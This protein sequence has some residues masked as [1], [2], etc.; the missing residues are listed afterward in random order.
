[1]LGNMNIVI[2]AN[3]FPSTTKGTLQRCVAS[4]NSIRRCSD[5]TGD[6]GKISVFDRIAL[7]DLKLVR[8]AGS[9]VAVG[10]GGS[11]PPELAWQPVA[12]AVVQSAASRVGADRCFLLR[13][14]GIRD[15]Q[16]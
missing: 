13:I 7:D 14:G 16:C 10:A 5:F 6:F 12:T 2:V 8:S 15:A 4:R 1:M 9:A 11:A 3:I